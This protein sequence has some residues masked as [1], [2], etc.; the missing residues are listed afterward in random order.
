MSVRTHSILTEFQGACISFNNLF[1]RKIE[2]AWLLKI[3]DFPKW[4][5]ILYAQGHAD[6]P[7]PGSSGNFYILVVL[8]DVVETQLVLGNVSS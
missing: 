3:Q 7:V 6:S 8:Q 4:R 1:R 5:L 2:L